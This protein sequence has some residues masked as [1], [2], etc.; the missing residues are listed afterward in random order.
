MRQNNI[1]W[2]PLD[3]PLIPKE[4]TLDNI[5]E[6]YSYVPDLDTETEKKYAAEKRH[7]AYAWNV[8]K[9]HV[10]KHSYQSKTPPLSLYETQNDDVA[11]TWTDEARALCPGLIDYIEKHLPFSKLKYVSA[12]SSRGTVPMH[13]DHTENIPLE[14]K[15]YYTEND[16]CYYRLV[17]DGKI[18]KDSF[19]IWTKKLGKVY[20]RMPEN[21]PGW[22]MGSYSCGHGNDEELPTQKLLLYV[23]GDLDLSRH[24]NLIQNSFERFKDYSIVKDYEV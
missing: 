8:L 13:V 19:Y 5:K 11:W 16:P 23:M 7:H 4:L 15:I 17:L 3:L 21:S 2:V 6:N 24:K 20:C 1:L 12:I 14:E 9:L 10:P 22:A 18:N